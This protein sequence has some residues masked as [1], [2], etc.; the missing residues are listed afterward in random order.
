LADKYSGKI[1]TK[2]CCTW[3]RPNPILYTFL[4][5]ISSKKPLLGGAS[6][7]L[8]ADSNVIVPES[9]GSTAVRLPAK[10]DALNLGLGVAVL[11]TIGVRRRIVGLVNKTLDRAIVEPSGDGA[12]GGEVV[13]EALPLVGGD[14][15]G[16]GDAVGGEIGEG[17][18][19]GFVV[20]HENLALATDAEVLALALGCVRHGDEGDVG[21]VK[22]LFR[23]HPGPNIDV[24]TGNG[25]GAK[26]FVSAEAIGAT[27]DLDRVGTTVTS[28]LIENNLSTLVAVGSICRPSYLIPT[29]LEILSDLAECERKHRKC[30]KSNLAKHDEL[31]MDWKKKKNKNRKVNGMLRE[32]PRCQGQAKRYIYK[33]CTVHWQDAML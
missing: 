8:G 17:S 11:P 19:V 31:D 9:V 2:K 25:I 30:S 20:E 24:T 23:L 18:V 6:D 10:V 16:G 13:L 32:K 12:I 4:P 1:D 28:C 26:E 15:L 3:Q 22:G 14:A 7:A 29:A 5:S 21:I 27:S 33:E